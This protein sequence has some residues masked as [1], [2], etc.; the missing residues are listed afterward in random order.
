MSIDSR[1]CS[2][3][4]HAHAPLRAVRVPA[5]RDTA[6]YRQRYAPTPSSL[7]PKAE[8]GDFVVDWTEP[9]ELK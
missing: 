5:A 7:R 8:T 2:H 6:E 4:I 3:P 9:E 1:V